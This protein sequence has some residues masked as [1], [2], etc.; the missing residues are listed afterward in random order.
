LVRDWA[1]RHD[2]TADDATLL[3]RCLIAMDTVFL[4]HWIERAKALAAAARRRV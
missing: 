1:D 4:E 2:L 3:D